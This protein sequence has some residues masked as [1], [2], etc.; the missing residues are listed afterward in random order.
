[1]CYHTT[2]IADIFH[3]L[4]L[5]LSIIIYNADMCLEILITLVFSSFISIR[6]HLPVSI[7]VL[8]IPCISVS[9]LASSTRP[10]AYFTELITCSPTLKFP[11]P[12]TASLVT[13]SHYKSSR[14]GDKQHP[15]VSPLPLF[16]LLVSPW[17]SNLTFWSV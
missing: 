3:I 9:I 10:S 11:N 6:Q 5:F 15:S 13:Y 14:D 7:S 12:S 17:S 4:P 2:Q 1:M 16:T 8:V